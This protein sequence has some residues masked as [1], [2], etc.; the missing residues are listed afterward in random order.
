MIKNLSYNDPKINQ[1]VI[2]QV[3]RPFSFF[4]RIKLGGIG[5]GRLPIEKCSREIEQLIDLDNNTNY[6]NFELRPK[7]IVL[8][9]RSL[10]ETYGLI[11]PYYKLSIIKSSPQIYT[12]HIDHHFVSVRI[13]QK[14]FVAKILS[15][16]LEF[17]KRFEKL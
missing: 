5:L 12:L 3:G 9:F 16:K 10:L 14:K 15:S 6:C 7:G 13:R 17:D 4:E 2:E 8:R 11:I 1:F